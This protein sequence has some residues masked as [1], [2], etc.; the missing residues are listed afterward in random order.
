MCPW[1]QHK[2]AVKDMQDPHLS[3]FLAAELRAHTPFFGTGAGPINSEK[4]SVRMGILH[5][6]SVD[7][8]FGYTKDQKLVD[9]LSFYFYA[10]LARECRI[11]QHVGGVILL[12]LACCRKI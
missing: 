11:D 2:P 6:L 3:N 4:N 5:R 10:G 7:M 12:G 8:K 1:A 9:Y